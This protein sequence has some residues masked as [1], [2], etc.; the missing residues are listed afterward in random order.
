MVFTAS[1]LDKRNSVGIK[2][3][4]LHAGSFGI[5]SDR[6]PLSLSDRQKAGPSS[7]LTVVTQSDLRRENGA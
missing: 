1:L 3:A 4:S 7:V 5:A 2:L 6:I